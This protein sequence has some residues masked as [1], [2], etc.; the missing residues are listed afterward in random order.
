MYA[1]NTHIPKVGEAH[2]PDIALALCPRCVVSTWLYMASC[3]VT[4]WT[5]LVQKAIYSLTKGYIVY[6]LWNSNGKIQPHL[7]QI[8]HL[9]HSF[10]SL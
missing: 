1:S 7:Y 4:P 2:H 10:S 3:R 8:S 6:V 9:W 5:F